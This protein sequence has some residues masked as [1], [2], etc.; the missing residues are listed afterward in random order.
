MS[1]QQRF[2]R[3][4]LKALSNWPARKLRLRASGG[5]KGIINEKLK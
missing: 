3:N 5:N 4:V 1:V 2:A